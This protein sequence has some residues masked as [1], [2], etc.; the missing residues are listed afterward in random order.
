MLV[1]DKV[2]SDHFFQMTLQKLIKKK[3][4]RKKYRTNNP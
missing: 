2:K 1:S 3:L 4:L